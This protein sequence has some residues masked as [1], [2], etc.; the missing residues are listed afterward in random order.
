MS[1][2]A[3][4]SAVAPL[5]AQQIAT[6]APTHNRTAPRVTIDVDTVPLTSV[7]QLI[8]RHAGLIVLFDDAA[9]PSGVRVTM[10][11]RN[12]A[13]TDAFDQALRGTGLIAHIRDEGDVTIRLGASRVTDGTITG[14]VIDASTK[15]PLRGAKIGI[16]AAS[17]VTESQEDGT[18]KLA[19]VSDGSH[20]ITVKLIGYAKRVQTAAVQNG[21]TATMT[22]ALTPSASPLDQ[23]VVTGTVI[24]TERRAVP[25]AMTVITGKELEQRGITHIDQLF[26]GDVPGVFS[27]NQGSET[28]NFAP[29][30]VSMASRGATSL[31]GF[32]PGGN[33]GDAVTQNIKTYVDGVELADPT[34]LGLI[35]PKSIERIEILTGPQASTIYG[36]GAING[37]MQI[38]TKRGST[39]RPQLVLNLSS[40]VLQNN[41][42]P[43]LA[44]QHDYSAQISSV[45]GRLSYNLGGSWNY[46]GPWT[47]AIHTSTTSGFGGVRA[48]YNT[49]TVDVTGRQTLS[50]NKVTSYPNQGGIIKR[51]EGVYTTDMLAYPYTPYR[52][53]S[54]AQ[55]LGLTVTHTLASWWS[56]TVTLGH[57]ETTPDIRASS[58]TYQTPDDTLLMVQSSTETRTSLAYNTT[59]QLPLGTFARATLTL[60]ADGWRTMM[61][62]LYSSSRALTGSLS[63]PSVNRQPAHDRG[64]FAQGQVGFYDAVFLTYGLRAEY[65]PFFGAQANPNVVPRYGIALTQT[66]GPLTAKLRGSYGHSTR[67]P[68]RGVADAIPASRNGTYYTSRFGN[69]LIQLAN[70]DLLPE[71]Q[72]GGEAGLELYAGTRASLIVTRYNQ[73]VDN[74]IMGAKVDSARSL[75]PDPFGQCF[76]NP[77]QCGY[78]YFKQSENLNI[79]SIRN[80]GWELQSTVTTGPFTTKGTYSWT[81]SRLIGIT[82][83]Y[84]AQFPGYH[85]GGTFQRFAEHTW[86]LDIG[87]V[88]G[89][90]SVSYNL[91]GQ[92]KMSPRDIYGGTP[93]DA[94]MAISNLRLQSLA[95]RTSPPPDYAPTVPG[96][97]LGDLNVSQRMTRTMEGILQIQNLGNRY[98]NDTGIDIASLGRQ[99]K[100]GLRVRL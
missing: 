13:A 21:S 62:S 24:P 56:Q 71:Q 60:G 7:L 22:I 89:G 26:H 31:P 12:L 15:R 83:K 69:I 86:A 8:A 75:R 6:G 95:V 82:P 23:V 49:V 52:F 74:L 76:Y 72:R 39:T 92:G 99:T 57:D 61:T 29:G 33:Y 81:K 77:S 100:A 2:S 4:M 34:Y 84:R 43:S 20:T 91:Q 42:S 88:R 17:R 30:K 9:I 32:G 38:F 3:S 10:H 54:T 97:L 55:T 28:G 16:D 58:R 59:A 45:E 1:V 80:Q 50:T 93:G 25:N 96:Y 78:V 44:P 73:T 90:T 66:F 48:Q 27:L 36:S 67:P 98:R 5:G 51:N 40:G 79:G 65:N 11:V 18:F 70:P 63:S 94:L 68:G 87:Y 14:T 85:V 64:L 19:H 46:I 53:S 47:P 41:Y 35:D 37:V